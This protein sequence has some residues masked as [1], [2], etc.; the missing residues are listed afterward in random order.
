M[1]LFGVNWEEGEKKMGHRENLLL[2]RGFVCV[3]F[4][5]PKQDHVGFGVSLESEC[6]LVMDAFYCFIFLWF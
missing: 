3:I 2:R 5:Y 1:A 6:D 4:Q